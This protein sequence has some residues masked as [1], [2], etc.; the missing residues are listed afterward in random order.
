MSIE[1]VLVILLVALLGY[2][3]FLHIQ[4]AKKKYIHRIDC[5]KII[6]N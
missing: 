3:I 6:R 1:I 4:L 2:V 5:K